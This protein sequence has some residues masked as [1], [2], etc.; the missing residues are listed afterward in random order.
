MTVDMVEKGETP[1][2]SI[3][4]SRGLFAL[5]LTSVDAVALALVVAP[6]LSER[7]F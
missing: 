5:L 3:G 6:A 4:Q 7:N 2:V 1:S